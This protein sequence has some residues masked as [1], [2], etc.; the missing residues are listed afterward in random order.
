MLLFHNVITEAEVD[1]N[2]LRNNGEQADIAMI[3]ASNFGLRRMDV[4]MNVSS[5]N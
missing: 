5:W 4:I 3:N 1:K 2:N